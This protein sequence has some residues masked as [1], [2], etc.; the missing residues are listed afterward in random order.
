MAGVPR[1]CPLPRFFDPFK[2]TSCGFLSDT[3]LRRLLI[4][5]LSGSAHLI[6]EILCFLGGCVEIITILL[7]FIELLRHESII[8]NYE[9]KSQDFANK[10][11][12]RESKYP[13]HGEPP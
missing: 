7:C 2:S 1:F 9:A 13:G 6:Q 11:K 10:L 12:K 3:G 4:L 5:D 8:P